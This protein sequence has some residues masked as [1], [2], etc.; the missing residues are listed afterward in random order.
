ME[1]LLDASFVEVVAPALARP[2]ITRPLSR[3]AESTAPSGRIGYGGTACLA[4]KRQAIQSPPLMGRSP[5]HV[6]ESGG[7]LSPANS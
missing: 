1:G 6:E 5:A 4:L 2:R 7:T 3:L